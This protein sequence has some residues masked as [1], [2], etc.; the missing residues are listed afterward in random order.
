MTT[1]QTPETTPTEPAVVAEPAKKS[2]VRRNL[3][4]AGSAAGLV[5][6]G[7]TLAANINLNS[8]ENVEFG[9][10]VAGT[11]AC[12]EDGFTINPVTSYDNENSIFRIDYVEVSGL[13]LTPEGTG[14][15]AGG[16]NSQADA[17]AA[18]PGEYYNGS[19]WQRTCDGVVLDFKA[20]TDDTT[21]WNMT[22]DGYSFNN[23]NSISTPI[24]WANDYGDVTNF[25]F[26]VAYD[27]FDAGDDGTA[28]Y[29][30]VRDDNWEWGALWLTEPDEIDF[31]TPSNS[32]FRFGVDGGRDG[33]TDD[34]YARPNAAAISKITV[35]S[36]SS[37]PESYYLSNT[38]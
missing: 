29:G 7:S 28:V 13:N 14:Y 5:G 27:I 12:D 38:P 10:G 16:Y 1:N 22:R 26:A 19:Q 21:Y 11:T 35:S 31:S 17:I 6:I 33:D 37:F 15:S 8:G 30:V 3:I 18:H 32:T 36:M 9:Q 2:K 23:T 4:L 20:Y 25:G 34:F 24:G